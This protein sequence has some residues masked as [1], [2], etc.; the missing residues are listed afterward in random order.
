MYQWYKNAQICYVYLEDYQQDGEYHLARCK[1]FT[2]GWTLRR[3][4]LPTMNGISETLS[5]IVLIEELIAPSSVEFYDQNWKEVGTK[6]ILCN[7]IAQITSIDRDVLLRRDAASCSVAQ[8]TSWAAFRSTTRVEDAAYYLMGLFNVF[9]H[10]LYGE[11]RRAFTRLQEEIIKQTEDSTICA[12]KSIEASSPWECR[13]TL[14]HSPAEFAADVPTNTLALRSHEYI[15]FP[16]PTL[17][18]RGLVL[19]LPVYEPTTDTRDILVC[20]AI[21]SR[22]GTSLNRLERLCVRLRSINLSPETFQRVD[23]TS[24]SV[25][26]GMI[27]QFSNHDPFCHPSWKG[28]FIDR[29]R[30][31]ARLPFPQKAIRTAHGRLLRLGLPMVLCGA[32]AKED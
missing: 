1:W 29:T 6:Q 16:P 3:C 12:W 4:F 9:M 26:R 10:M 22:E 5:N 17:N 30:E 20:M 31:I 24:W 13:G 23:Q 25:F 14:A 7:Q 19:T 28:S 27:V 21:S 18:S 8:R 11:G 2:R 32:K 15:N